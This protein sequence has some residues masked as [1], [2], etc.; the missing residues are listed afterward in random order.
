MTSRTSAKCTLWVNRAIA[1]LMGL[2]CV[3]L[4]ALTF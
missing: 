1:V 3:F 2:L 4:Y